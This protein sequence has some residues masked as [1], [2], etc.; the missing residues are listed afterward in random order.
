M[1]TD[2]DKVAAIAVEADA[3]IDEPM[4]AEVSPTRPN[5]SVVLA[6]RLTSED[7]AAIEALAARTEMPV[8][9]LLRIWIAAGLASSQ[10]LTVSSA[11]E[12]LSADLALLRQ[13]T[14]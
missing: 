6:V 11:V 2:A 4:P 5:K 14:A 7:S 9:A 8:S 10:T 12:R 3:T 1:S 13:L